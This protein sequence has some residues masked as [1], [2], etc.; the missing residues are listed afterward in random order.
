MKLKNQKKYYLDDDNTFKPCYERCASCSKGGD[1]F[2]NNCNECLK[3]KSVYLFHFIFNQN[4]QCINDKEKPF[5]TYLDEEDNTYKKCMIHV[6]VVLKLGDRNDHKCITCAPGYYFTYDEPGKCVPEEKKCERCYLDKEDDT[7]KKCY[8]TCLTCFRGGTFENH[9]CEICDQSL[10]GS[11]IYHFIYNIPGNCYS[12][13]NIPNGLYLDKNDNTFKKCYWKCQNC[14]ELGDDISNKCT[15]CLK[16]EAGEYIYALIYNQPGQCIVF[17]TAPVGITYNNRTNTYEKCH[18]RCGSCYGEGTDE[19]NKCSLCSYSYDA[20]ID[21]YINITHFYYKDKEKG[22]CY[23]EN[24]KPPYTFLNEKTNTYEQCYPR[25]FT[26][27]KPG[28]EEHHNCDSCKLDNENNTYLWWIVDNIGQCI[29]SGEAPNNTYLNTENNT[30]LYCYESCG[31][32]TELGNKTDHK[33]TSCAKDEIIGEYLYHFT[34]INPTNCID[35]DLQPANTYLD[36]EDNTYKLCYERCESCSV[37]GTYQ[38]MNCDTCKIKYYTI[39]DKPGQCVTKEDAP[40]NVYFDE[41][42][43]VFINC[44]E[45]CAT[46][47]SNGNSSQ[48][49]CNSCLQDETFK[50]YF[51]DGKIGQCVNLTIIGDNYYLKKGVYYKCYE[52]CGI[53]SKGGNRINNNCE[54]CLKDDNG[55]YLYHFIYNQT[56]QCISEKEKPNNLF[57]NDTNNTY[58]LCPS[59]SIISDGACYQLLSLNE[60]ISELGNNDFVLTLL[61]QTYENPNENYTFLVTTNTSDI[62]IYVNKIKEVFNIPKNSHL[63]VGI[64]TIKNKDE[65]TSRF[66]SRVFTDDG[67]ELDII[68]FNDDILIVNL[69]FNGTQTLTPKLAKYIHDYDIEYDVFD[70]KNKFYN[71]YCASFQDQNGHDVTLEERQKYYYYNYCGNCKYISINYIKFFKKRIN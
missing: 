13:D 45:T 50:Y 55:N 62:D 4:E 36:K 20:V 16:N 39:I 1:A 58:I 42:K 49:N 68:E 53:C 19:E 2:S 18:K 17:G 27:S 29:T 5:N 44:Y 26:C 32:C 57:L 24:E 12:Y 30:Y 67:T 54:E 7:Y 21:S 63:L 33:C 15:E 59:G 56:G 70:P 40:K 48:N 66:I 28:D 38:N 46:C 35:E 11:F 25:C 14:K 8:Y 61:N 60:L 51:L 34:E 69:E 9:N 31:S 22:N 43:Q 71:D 47:S 6:E 52:T 23:Y 3:N 65:T 41:S 37:G 10:N 64:L